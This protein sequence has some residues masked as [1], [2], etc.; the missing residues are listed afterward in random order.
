M[1]LQQKG[2]RVRLVLAFGDGCVARPFVLVDLGRKRLR[3][4]LE[5]RLR[6]GLATLDFFRRC[7]DVRHWVE[8][9]HFVRDFAVDYGLDL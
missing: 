3:R 2:D 8:S 1:A 4:K 7:L 6:V 9:L 5:P